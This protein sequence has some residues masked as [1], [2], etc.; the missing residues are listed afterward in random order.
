MESTNLEA[1]LRNLATGVEVLN[2]KF[3][4]LSSSISNINKG[5]RDKEERLRE[6]E[7]KHVKL[8]TKTASDTDYLCLN[9]E[10]NNENIEELRKEVN[11]KLIKIATAV[12]IL[13]AAAGQADKILKLF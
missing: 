4:T 3:D 2:S 13:A 12:S 9:V 11:K 10:K 8:S 6:L 7:N 1:L 5:C